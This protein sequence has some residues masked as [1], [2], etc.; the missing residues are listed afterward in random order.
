M[1]FV[2][3]L[4]LRIAKLELVLKCLKSLFC[5]HFQR[6]FDETSLMSLV[7]LSIQYLN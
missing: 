6:D 4:T 5:S 3:K 1:K 7:Y 2:Y